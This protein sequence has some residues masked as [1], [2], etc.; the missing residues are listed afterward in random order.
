MSYKTK[1]FLYFASFII[2]AVTYYNST[3]TESVSSNNNEI[4]TNNVE[5]TTIQGLN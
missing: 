4:V 2:A 3:Y 5:Q 1:S